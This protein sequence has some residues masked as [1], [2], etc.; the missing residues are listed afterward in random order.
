M[1]VNFAKLSHT[2]ITRILMD[3]ILH[4]FLPRDYETNHIR[5]SDTIL[6][7][8]NI[9]TEEPHCLCCGEFVLQNINHTRF[10]FYHFSKLKWHCY[11][12]LFA[13]QDRDLPI[14]PSQYNGYWYHR[15]PTSHCIVFVTI[16]YS[17]FST[18]MV[19]AIR[20]RLLRH[21]LYFSLKELH[22]FYVAYF[23]SVSNYLAMCKCI[24]FPRTFCNKIKTSVANR[25]INTSVF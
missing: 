15:V 11:L 5:Q 13:M 17:W 25:T 24:V 6:I 8:M 20:Q 12:K 9:T 10:F 18:N 23:L 2:V 16:N 3:S 1:W 14:L 4:Q 21:S 22:F 19:N 7:L